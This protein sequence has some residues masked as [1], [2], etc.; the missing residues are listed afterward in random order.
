MTSK[1][2]QIKNSLI[3]ILPVAVGAAIPLITLPIFTR[4]LTKEDYGILALAQVYA[5]FVTS[6]A[7]FGLT[8][9]YERNFF[10]CREDKR[11]A[12]LLY[13]TLLFV[14]ATISFSG[15]ITYILRD[16]FSRWVIGSSGYGDFLFWTYCSTSIMSLKVYFLTFFK[17]MEQ[18][19]PFAWY[20][21]DENLLG[22]L[23]SLILVVY[24]GVGVVGLVWG[25]LIASLL[26]FSALVF[27]FLRLMPPAFDSLLLKDSLRLS[28][29]LTPRIFLG[30]VGSQ[31]DKYMIGLL[32]TVGGVGIYSIGQK[33]ANVTFTGMTAIQNVFSPQVYKRMFEL[34][35]EGGDSV[36]RYLTPFM[37]ISISLGLVIALFSEEI[38]WLLTPKPFHGAVDIVTI[39][40]MLYGSYFFGKQPQLI[41]AKKT[42]VTSL[43]TVVS[44][45]LMIAINIPFIQQWGAMGAAW[46]TLLAGLISGAISVVVSQHYYEIRWEYGK[47][48]SIFFIFFG[49]ALAMILLR[50]F[51]ISYGIRLMFKLISLAGYVYLGMK[52]DLL[53][54]QNYR[55]VRKMI[56]PVRA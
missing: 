17:N 35:E 21:I 6:L 47:A 3:Y 9:A 8:A 11:A 7:N 24:A 54:M 51:D 16:V 40:S 28:Y 53:T 39:L 30:V 37:Y 45:G 2:Q 25:Q 44:I 15:L 50:H 49:S 33:V 12:A 18:A 27:R 10:E 41:F 14:L 23:F 13:S 29:P 55:L 20:T 4:I 46:G 34:G 42:H 32:S 38:I 48:C 22:V 36:G 26:I 52:I 31:F 5:L 56:S 19:K 43:L 1:E